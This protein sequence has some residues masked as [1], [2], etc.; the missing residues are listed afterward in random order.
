VATASGKEGIESK[1]G[2]IVRADGS[3]LSRGSDSA[4]KKAS[5]EQSGQIEELKHEH[6]ALLSRLRKLEQTF[7]RD[8]GVVKDDVHLQIE[9]TEKRI[10]K[11]VLEE[12][13]IRIRQIVG[14][15]SEKIASLEPTK[16]YG[17]KLALDF[18][19]EQ[20]SQVSTPFNEEPE[21]EYDTCDMS[22]FSSIQASGGRRES[23]FWKSP[24]RDESPKKEVSLA[25]L[26]D[27]RRRLQ[28][29]GNAARSITS[30]LSG[31]TAESVAHQQPAKLDYSGLQT[32]DFAAQRFAAPDPFSPLQMAAPAKAPGDSP[33][34][35]DAEMAR[36]ADLRR[37]ASSVL[38]AAESQCSQAMAN[39]AA[40]SQ[41]PPMW[42]HSVSQQATVQH[43][44]TD[45]ARGSRM[46][47]AI[48]GADNHPG[49]LR[50]A[51][52]HQDHQEAPFD[53][54]PVPA[55]PEM[56]GGV[57]HGVPAHAPAAPAWDGSRG[58]LSQRAAPQMEVNHRSLSPRGAPQ[59]PSAVPRRSTQRRMTG[60]TMHVPWNAA[61]GGGEWEGTVENEGRLV[62]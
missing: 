23:E 27:N 25:E 52:S 45:A 34:G 17:S 22:D 29:I 42:N 47:A 7:V 59:I 2:T 53:S 20:T 9:A 31:S 28:N 11:R 24:S 61:G 43:H 13:D 57:R 51:A 55:A 6:E 10:F 56:R 46:S 62:F 33:D 15:S 5:S 35:L 4:P 54:S 38:Q 44:G 40:S 58:S 18:S 49:R 8:L 60:Q 39:A 32:P 1:V 36:L 41:A 14:A 21:Q 19:V 16:P 30:S 26:A 37:F 12:L 48:F 50:D 3:S